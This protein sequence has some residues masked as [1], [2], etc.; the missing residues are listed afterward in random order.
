MSQIPNVQIPGGASGSVNLEFPLGEIVFVVG[1]NGSGKSA[2]V[3]YIQKAV[4]QAGHPTIVMMAHRQ[5]SLQADAPNIAPAQILEFSRSINS[6]SL[7]ENSRSYEQSQEQRAIHALSKFLQQRTN[8]HHNL[9]EESK[10]LDFVR[11]KFDQDFPDP[12]EALNRV[13]KYGGLKI[14]ITLSDSSEFQAHYINSK[15]ASTKIGISRLSDGERATVL[16]AA[17]IIGADSNSLIVIDE[18]ERHLHRAISHPLIEGLVQLRPD[19]G[20]LISTH[21]LSLLSSAAGSMIIVPRR[22]I[23]SGKVPSAFELKT[24]NDASML[25]PEIGEAILGARKTLL[26]VEGSLTSLDRRLYQI[27]FPTIS[28]HPKGNCTAVIRAVN[29]VRE[30]PDSDIEVFG[31]IDA[32]DRDVSELPKLEASGVF[33]IPYVSVEALLLCQE[34]RSAVATGLS[35]K[36]G[37]SAGDIEVSAIKAVWEKLADEDVVSKLV[38]RKVAARVRDKIVQ[39]VPTP[40]EIS[41]SKSG[42]VALDIEPFFK[43][44]STKLDGIIKAGDFD[45]LASK[46]QL[47]EADV[48]D[49]FAHKYGFK[50]S[51]GYFDSAL[52]VLQNSSALNAAVTA[53]LGKIAPILQKSLGGGG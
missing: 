14:Q 39:L 48:F 50:N 53:R 43:M 18:P 21:D 45:A 28:V 31:I 13:L 6:Y 42:T 9:D 19:C 25:P 4:R 23:W 17:Q 35:A 22:C 7:Q 30:F 3:D 36:L 38:A 32:D 47:R 2:L 40:K 11:P 12:L 16:I 1:P 33:A 49:V 8:W 24:L 29:G 41:V 26:F 44:E 51:K 10:K 34:L 46:W 20:Y 5:S 52:K 27:L 37:L 15:E